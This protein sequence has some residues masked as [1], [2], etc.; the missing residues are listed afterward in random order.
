MLCF[1]R[2]DILIILQKRNN[3]TRKNRVKFVSIWKCIFV[4]KHKHWLMR[5]I[6][7]FI[8]LTLAYKFLC[9]PYDFSLSGCIF[10]FFF[11]FSFLVLSLIVT[12]Y[13]CLFLLFP[14]LSFD[15]S[16]REVWRLDKVKWSR[17]LVHK[18]RECHG[19]KAISRLK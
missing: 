5:I 3:R 17:H 15:Y 19:L 2:K 11:S 12:L 8:S 14:F 4:Q 16:L 7:L 10:L 9:F 6:T 13:L 1:L 18:Q